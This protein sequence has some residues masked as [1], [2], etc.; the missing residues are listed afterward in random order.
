ML[1]C[2]CIQSIVLKD[3]FLD[4][5]T[6]AQTLCSSYQYQKIYT[7]NKPT[8][9]TQYLAINVLLLISLFI[10]VFMLTP[11]FM[12]QL[13]L[14][15]TLLLMFMLLLSLMLMLLF[16]LLCFCWC[17]SIIQ[18]YWRQY[19]H[20]VRIIFPRTLVLYLSD[21]WLSYIWLEHLNTRR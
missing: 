19:T 6:L 7:D 15:L 4:H 20:N 9:I 21:L 8:V 12:L 10:S 5:Q 3:S 14:L 18:K 16:M 1:W 17:Y 11:L 2:S 13:L